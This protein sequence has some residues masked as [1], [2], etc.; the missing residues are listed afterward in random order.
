V[1]LAVLVAMAAVVA[2]LGSS[3]EPVRQASPTSSSTLPGY[4][5]DP[6][7]IRPIVPWLAAPA[8]PAPGP[9]PPVPP[10]CMPSQLVVVDVYGEGATGHAADFVEVENS[11][12]QPCSIA[13]RPVVELRDARG[14][15]VARSGQAGPFICSG[16]GTNDTPG[17]WLVP[18]GSVQVRPPHGVGERTMQGGLPFFTLAQGQCPGGVFPEGSRLFLV[19][20]QGRVPIADAEGPLPFD[21][22]CDDSPGSYPPPGRP[23]LLVGFFQGIPV[24][25]FV[26]N[27]KVTVEIV[28]PAQIRAGS[29]LR[30]RMRTRVSGN[31]FL[32]VLGCPGYTQRILGVSEE[33]HRLNCEGLYDTLERRLLFDQ[34]FDMVLRVPRSAKPGR[35]KLTWELDPPFGRARASADIEITRG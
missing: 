13:G 31:V 30:Y 9:A 35:W 15:L 14:R 24:V 12:S 29:K 25:D 3:G 8:P 4:P 33:R 23:Q 22:R 1:G 18:A 5:A 32:G 2:L 21:Y 20:S 28:A 6:A 7:S 34:W 26:D 16:C 17:P 10:L 11:S 19:L 27:D